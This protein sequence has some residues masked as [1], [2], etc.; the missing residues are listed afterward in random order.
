MAHNLLLV[1]FKRERVQ[2]SGFF[3]EGQALNPPPNLD[4]IPLH[5]ISGSGIK[6]VGFTQMKGIW[7]KYK[8]WLLIWIF[9]SAYWVIKSIKMMKSIDLQIDGS[10]HGHSNQSCG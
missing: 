1:Y 5:G 10:D 2:G 9:Y 8:V 4:F 7:K 6:T 3:A